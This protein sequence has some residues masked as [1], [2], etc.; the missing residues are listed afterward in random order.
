M[1]PG[2]HIRE[3]HLPVSLLPSQPRLPLSMSWISAVLDAGTG[4]LSFSFPQWQVREAVTNIP[5]FPYSWQAFLLPSGPDSLLTWDLHP[6]TTSHLLPWDL[7]N[8]VQAWVLGSQP[9]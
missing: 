6:P 9:Q 5:H 2:L 1:Q 3:G 8:M 4:E 7:L